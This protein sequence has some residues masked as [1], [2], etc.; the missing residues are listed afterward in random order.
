MQAAGIK[1]RGKNNGAD[2]LWGA[3]S[4][5]GWDTYLQ[6]HNE[7]GSLRSRV[8]QKTGQMNEGWRGM[9][10]QDLMNYKGKMFDLSGKVAVVTGASSGLG[11]QMAYSVTSSNRA[12]SLAF[13]DSSSA[14]IIIIWRKTSYCK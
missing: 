13:G 2:G 11:V 4:Q 5:A 6:T 14:F 8:N 9:S 1:L 7:D 12:F 10:D 3:S